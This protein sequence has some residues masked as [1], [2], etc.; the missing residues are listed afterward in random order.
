MDVLWW[1]IVYVCVLVCALV[2]MAH[3]LFSS[4]L[5]LSN[6]PLSCTQCVLHSQFTD[7]ETEAQRTCVLQ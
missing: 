2:C 6:Y 1:T 7:K 3:F 4:S 5:V